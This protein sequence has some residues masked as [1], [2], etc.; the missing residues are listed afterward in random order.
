LLTAWKTKS[1][2]GDGKGY[3]K[4]R[5]NVPPKSHATTVYRGKHKKDLGY[6]MR[7][8]KAVIQ[9]KTG[10]MARLLVLPVQAKAG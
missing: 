1:S 3:K 7:R 9:Q 8:S 5:S 4:P 10:H 6:W 2:K